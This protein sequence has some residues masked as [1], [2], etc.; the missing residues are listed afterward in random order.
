MVALAAVLGA[1]WL[2]FVPVT[3]VYVTD[4]GPGDRERG[5]RDISTVY[6]WW[7]HD[8]VLVYSDAAL[9]QPTHVVRGV[10]L[11]CG[12][13]VTTG[14][15]EQS[16]RESGGPRVCADLE[17]SRRWTGLSLLVLGVVAV[18]VASKLPV[19]PERYRNRYR[20]PYSQRRAL[21]R[22]R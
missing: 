1:A 3:A 11:N 20:Q 15:H 10:R 21:R 19:E 7:A 14:P 16:L 13:T 4:N 18:F 17:S 12:N 8:E 9:N 6:S 5:P 22:A 2:L